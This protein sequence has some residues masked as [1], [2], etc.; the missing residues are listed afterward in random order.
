MTQRC[1]NCDGLLVM[2]T[3]RD[4]LESENVPL[5][6]YKCI[7]CGRMFEPTY[8][9]HRLFGPSQQEIKNLQLTTKG[10]PSKRKA[11]TR[12][13]LNKLDDLPMGQL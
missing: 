7:L 1:T 11:R 9:R 3:M 8:N 2:E 10:V 12:V 6:I 5:D 4:L 13:G